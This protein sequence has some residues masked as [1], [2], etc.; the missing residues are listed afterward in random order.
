MAADVLNYVRQGN[1]LVC[2]S[3]RLAR[4]LKYQYAQTQIRQGRHAWVTPDIL[5]WAAWLQRCWNEMNSGES[6]VQM[7]LGQEQQLF[8]WQQL[9]Q[10]SGYSRQLLQVRATARQALHAW[11]TARQWQIPV[12]PTGLYL[13]EDAQAFLSW[14]RAYR[15][16]CKD[17]SLIDAA[18]IP[19]LLSAGTPYIKRLKPIALAGFDDLTPMQKTLI[20]ALA[21]VETDVEMIPNEHR[22]RDVSATFYPDNRGEIVAAALWCRRLLESG[23]GEDIGVVVP[24]LRSLYT[25]IQNTFDDVLT[26]GKILAGHEAEARPYSITLGLPL[27]RYPVI[28]TALDIL[29]LG[30]LT[31]A[32]PL[33]SAVLRS[34]FIRAAE[35]EGQRRAQL[36]ACLHKYGEHRMPLN[37]LQDIAGRH[38][39]A[40]GIPRRFLDNGQ[41]YLEMLH[42]AGVK[43]PAHDWPALFSALLACFGWPGDRA[44]DSAEY[45][46]VVEW[47]SIMEKFAAIDPT[48]AALS[49]REALVQLRQLAG[50]AGFQPETAETPVQIMGMTGAAGMQFD[51]L[52]VMGLDEES[53]PYQADPIA[54]I[55]IRLQ[56]DAGLPAAS[57][58]LVLAQASRD[59]QR[60]IHSARDTVLSYPCN[61]KDRPLRPSPLIR[62]YLQAQHDSTGDGRDYAYMLFASRRWVDTDDALAP[63]IPEGQAVVGGTALFGDQAA[64]PFRACA[65]HRLHAKGL[66]HRDIGLDAR[67]RG[68]LIHEVMQRLWGKLKDHATLCA[69]SG[70]ELDNAVNKSVRAALTAYRKKLPETLNATFVRLESARI[71]AL[72]HD[73]L[74]LERRRRPF[75]VSERE[76]RHRITMGDI[77]VSTRI[78]RIDVLDDGRA[79]IIDYKTGDPRTRHWLGERPDEPQLPLY[80]VTSG[81]KIA[82][83]VFARLSPGQSAFIG[84]AQ[85]QDL[86][87][88]VATLMETGG[89]ITEW[90]AL[91]D[92]WR[93]ALTGLAQA[94]RRGDARVDPK[95]PDTCRYCDLHALCRIYERDANYNFRGDGDD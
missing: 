64:C 67:E 28:K 39:P 46:T 75:R 33:L 52:W 94:F 86:L 5:P 45:Q 9:I 69:A 51:H 13:N 71:G 22:N 2:A 32:L 38:L 20:D 78:D 43:R 12:F 10:Q 88:G 68:S 60:L 55:P 16:H 19:D 49:Y 93:D 83:V 82:A 31:V 80:A 74:E 41:S 50:N 91:F 48:A 81:G 4:R 54:F 90:S 27:T 29:D 30:N 76:Y 56:R 36:D 53:W 89:A 44:L 73:W 47:R 35:T 65:R 15:G 34:P 66:E 3:S 84:V 79:V 59:T 40:E 87:P 37:S 18:D 63:A 92:A 85:E 7:L 42:S 17:N 72:V 61:D 8:I 77:E 26:P 57:A 6:H 11:N 70:A 23:G 58:E 21:R 62:Q 95:G 24:D 25:R 1:T 14:S